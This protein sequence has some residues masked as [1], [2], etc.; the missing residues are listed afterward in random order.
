MD[1]NALLGAL[2]N[3]TARAILAATSE[4]D[5]SAK[6]LD[7]RIDVSQTSIYR[8]LEQLTEN[9]LVHETL[10]LDRSGNHFKVYR[11]AITNVNIDI[12]S[13]EVR[14]RVEWHEDVSERFTRIWEEIR[15]DR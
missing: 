6:E 15:G 10:Q 11:A 1:E 2:E 9:G 13:G 8:Q 14:T 5:R 12:E 7:E 4:E 3:E